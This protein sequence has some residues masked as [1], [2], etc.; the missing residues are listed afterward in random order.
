M[1]SDDSGNGPVGTCTCSTGSEV[2]LVYGL[3][4]SGGGK[5]DR[6]QCGVTD[7][8]CYYDNETLQCICPT[9]K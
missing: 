8:R 7:G 4:G 5:A 2:S 9:G 3:R 1:W 6:N